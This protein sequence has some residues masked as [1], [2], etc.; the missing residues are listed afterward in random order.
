MESII[1]CY[2]N[3]IRKEGYRI[4]ENEDGSGEVK[5]DSDIEGCYEYDR[6][7]ASKQELHIMLLQE[8]INATDAII[9]VMLEC[10][11]Q[12]LTVDHGDVHIIDFLDKI[13]Y[14][15]RELG[16][17]AFQLRYVEYELRDEVLLGG[18][19]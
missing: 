3:C 1:D 6:Q 10:L 8:R 4:I 13:R 11:D 12:S 15:Q 18:I 16:E 14:L 5:L 9:K 7:F 19:E 17:M 2:K